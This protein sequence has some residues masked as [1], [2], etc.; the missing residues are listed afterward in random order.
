MRSSR[1]HHHACGGQ[2]LRR[3]EACHNPPLLVANCPWTWPHCR[4]TSPGSLVL[5]ATGRVAHCRVRPKEPSQGS[6]QSGNPMKISRSSLPLVTTLAGLLFAGSAMLGGGR[7]RSPSS[8]ALFIGGP[9]D[10]DGHCLRH[11]FRR[12]CPCRHLFRY[13]RS[14]PSHRERRRQYQLHD[15]DS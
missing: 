3:S 15:Q 12:Q 2:W 10:H 9:T 14:L 13:D 1:A 8:L 7:P 11:Q 4:L 5:R 6:N